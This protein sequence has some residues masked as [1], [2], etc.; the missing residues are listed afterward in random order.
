MASFLQLVIYFM[1]YGLM[2][3]FRIILALLPIRETVVTWFVLMFGLDALVWVI[4]KFGHFIDAKFGSSK[5][6]DMALILLANLILIAC[7]MM[8]VAFPIYATPQLMPTVR[9]TLETNDSV[10]MPARD[11]FTQTGTE[12]NAIGTL[13]QICEKHKLCVE[14]C[15]DFRTMY[16]WLFATYILTVLRLFVAIVL[17]DIVSFLCMVMDLREENITYTVNLPGGYHV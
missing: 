5:T 9:G 10:C 4:V 2:G 13:R 8:S 16:V 11:N 6:V 14:Q 17:W 3:H 1:V 7:F 15:R 12:W